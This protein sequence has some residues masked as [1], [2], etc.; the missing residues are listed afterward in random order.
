ML[1]S[2]LS[3]IVRK[4]VLAVRRPL[5]PNPVPGNKQLLIIPGASH[6]DL[7]DGGYTEPEGKGQAKNMIPWDRLEEFF[8]TNLENTVER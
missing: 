4:Q 5:E 3:H 1:P 6:C 2:A 8:K 7:Y